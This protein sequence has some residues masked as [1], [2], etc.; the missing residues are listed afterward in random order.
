M[1]QHASW[2]PLLVVSLLSI[3]CTPDRIIYQ[4]ADVLGA[5]Y[6]LYVVRE[7]GSHR[8][9]LASSP[10]TE[11]ACGVT[12]DRRIVFTRQTSAGGD[13]Y[14]VNEDGTGLAPLRTTMDDETCFGVTG[15]NMVV[16][17]VTLTQLNHD[18]YSVSANARPTDPSI[19]LSVSSLDDLPVAIGWDDRILYAKQEVTVP[20]DGHRYS[21]YSVNDDGTQP[22]RVVGVFEEPKY[23]AIAPGYRMI[24]QRPGEPPGGGLYSTTTNGMQ[25][26]ASLS[27]FVHYLGWKEDRFCG[28]T[29]TGRVLV[30]SRGV[31]PVDGQPTWSGQIYLMNDD[32]TKVVRMNPGPRSYNEV[33]LAASDEWVIVGRYPYEV[34]GAETGPTSLWSYPASGTGPPIQLAKAGSQTPFALSFQGLTIQGRVLFQMNEQ[35]SDTEWNQA[36]Y[37]I[38]PDGSALVTLTNSQGGPGAGVTGFT[39]YGKVVYSVQSRQYDLD[40]VP[41]SGPPPLTPLA[42]QPVE[43]WLSFIFY[44]D[45]SNRAA[46]CRRCRPLGVDPGGSPLPSLPPFPW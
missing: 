31:Y 34:D 37:S 29:P 36:N 44:T 26:T 13:L 40:I 38:A 25:T 19:P 39:N 46:R 22:G 18:L 15:H 45:Y 17:G 7:D 14:I 21:F 24:W 11:S 30:T 33:C 6:D 9:V 1:L 12:T 10:D 28:F 20:V 4:H 43:N 41:A 42:S 2:L 32:G 8:A 16:Y 27:N 3:A 5:Q 35:I 23:I